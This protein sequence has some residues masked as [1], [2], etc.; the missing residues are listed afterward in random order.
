MCLWWLE[1]RLVNPSSPN[2]S[3]S[4]PSTGSEPAFVGAHL[5]PRL[6]DRDR[7]PERAL[8][9]AGRLPLVALDDTAAEV[10]LPVGQWRLFPGGVDKRPVVPRRSAARAPC[11]EPVS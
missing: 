4:R 1:K 8:G 11:P 10:A 2:M 6:C 9:S 3:F 7:L 5:A